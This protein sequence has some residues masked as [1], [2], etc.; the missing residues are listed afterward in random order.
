MGMARNSVR[1][2]QL[3]TSQELPDNK[4]EEKSGIIPVLRRLCGI[5]TYDS[6]TGIYKT[7][8]ENLFSS[9]TQKAMCTQ[10]LTLSASRHN[11]TYRSLFKLKQNK[12]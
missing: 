5:A 9:L 8:S 10:I 2:E 6:H 11:A 12:S 1:R 7:H 3:N 4:K